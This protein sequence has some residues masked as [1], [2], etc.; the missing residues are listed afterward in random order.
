MMGA[1]GDL[2]PEG[3]A[4]WKRNAPLGIVAGTLPM[5]LGRALGRLPGPNDGVVRVEETEVEGMTARTL[6]PLGHSMLIASAAVGKRIERFF[7]VGSFE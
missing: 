6:V 3:Q 1:C 7:A 4:S 5:G 2:C